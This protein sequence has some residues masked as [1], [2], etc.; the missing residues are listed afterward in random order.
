MSTQSA[1]VASAAE[2]AAVLSTA[3][4]STAL[5]TT[6]PAAGGRADGWTR[7]R[8]VQFLRELAA[9]HCVSAAARAVGMSRQSAYQ[10]R[11]RLRGEPFDLAWDAAF[12]SC[13]DA[14]AEAAMERAANG[15]EIPHYH[16]G[17]LVGT[18]R[19]Y[20][21]RLTVALL[22][23]RDSLRRPSAPPWHPAAAYGSHNFGA[24]IARVGSGPDT[25][26]K[27]RR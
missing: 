21:E 1:P 15:V 2:T 4:P 22:R 17:E 24:L 5:A 16:K 7:S 18:S 27:Q 26:D 10:L 6:G 19:H 11:A 14:L 13:F 25:W 12:Q 23:I 3:T 9:T 20:D 8:Q